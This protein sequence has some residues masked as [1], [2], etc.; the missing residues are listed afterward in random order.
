MFSRERIDAACEVG[1]NGE[2]VERQRNSWCRFVHC[3]V[4]NISVATF[5]G[6]RFMLKNGLACL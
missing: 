1:E 6:V 5:G 3:F 4:D 2:G